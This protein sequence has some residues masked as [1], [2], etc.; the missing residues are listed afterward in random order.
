MIFTVLLYTSVIFALVYLQGQVQA[1][2]IWQMIGE[3][4]S[5][6]FLGAITYYSNLLLWSHIFKKS[7]EENITLEYLK[8]RLKE[9]EQENNH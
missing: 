8:K 1:E 7:Q 5:C 9:K 4:I 3:Y 2:N 6:I